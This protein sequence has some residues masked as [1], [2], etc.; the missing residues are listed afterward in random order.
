MEKPRGRWCHQPDKDK[1]TPAVLLPRDT[2]SGNSQGLESHSTRAPR[3]DDP[4]TDD[5][6]HKHSIEEQA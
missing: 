3:L 1:N 5:K 6:N 2:D 4:K